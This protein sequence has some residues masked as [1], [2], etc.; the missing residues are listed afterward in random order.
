VFCELRIA[1]A[2]RYDDLQNYSNERSIYLAKLRNVMEGPWQRWELGQL[3]DLSP[4]QV[5]S[6]VQVR[7]T[8]D[9]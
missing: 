4:S 1:L 6:P 8:P 7:S 3:V 2:R 9:F 5:M